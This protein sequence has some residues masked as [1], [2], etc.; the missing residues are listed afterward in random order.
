MLSGR[1][2]QVRRQ[3]GKDRPGDF[4]RTDQAIRHRET[5]N[6]T[7]PGKAI[8]AGRIIRAGRRRLSW[9]VSSTTF[10]RGVCHVQ[11]TLAILG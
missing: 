1:D 11:G 7:S 8:P 9:S 2:I 4:Q 10:I 6:V 3:L 5:G